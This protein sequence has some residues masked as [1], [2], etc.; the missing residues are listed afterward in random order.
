[1]LIE[2]TIDLLG[3]NAGSLAY[4]TIL[5][6]S[7]AIALQL[8]VSRNARLGSTVRRR[9]V[10]GLVLL[11]IFQIGLFFASGLIWQQNNQ[12]SS[13]LG[14]LDRSIALLS[15]V[16]LVWLW[17]FPEKNPAA[18]AGTLIALFIT[19]I[20]CIFAAVWWS[21]SIIVPL[22]QVYGLN[23]TAVDHAFQVFSLLICGAGI[24]ILAAVRAP[25]W[26]YGIAMFSLL[27]CGHLFQLFFPTSG[28]FPVV[29]RLFE[30][31]AYPFLIVLPQRNLIQTAVVAEEPVLQE[32]QTIQQ[33]SAPAE[34][35][36]VQSI[37]PAIL[38]ALLAFIDM[39]GDYQACQRVVS[40]L[41]GAA[42]A[43]Q[44][45]LVSPPDPQ[46][47]IHIECGY[48]QAARQYVDEAWVDGREL[49]ILTSC[50]KMGRSPEAFRRL[51][52][53]RSSEPGSSL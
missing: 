29:L 18:D 10:F 25:A 19:L 12:T 6:F 33:A 8:A 36:T 45:F 43:E 13:L 5:A 53:T 27:G 40:I 51:C 47:L 49:P 16:V 42:H 48:D 46:G 3:S 4:H 44:V 14:L 17:G 22:T 23:G 24:V 7:I 2:A 31:A 26:S 41:A 15:L 50:L 30:M 39:P 28:N 9:L 32:D 52:I 21:R 20:G 37:D 1:M 11:L 34:L 38:K 35:T